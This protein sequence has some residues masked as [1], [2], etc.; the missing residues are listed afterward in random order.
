[1][2]NHDPNS[3]NWQVR[4]LKADAAEHF[5]ECDKR[6][7]IHQ[8]Y[9]HNLI[10]EVKYVVNTND[11]GL[12]VSVELRTRYIS[13]SPAPCEW[14][15]SMMVEALQL[16]LEVVKQCG[17][18]SILVR[19]AHF[20]N[21]V[22]EYGQPRFVDFDSFVPLEIGRAVTW[23]SYGEFVQC[24]FRPTV[25]IMRGYEQIVRSLMAADSVFNSRLT[26]L[27]HPI[28][29]ALI[30]RFRVDG[31]VTTLNSRVRFL[32]SNSVWN[33]ASQLS[34]SQISS[35]GITVGE[36][37]VVNIRY[38]KL[39]RLSV[40]FL[41]AAVKVSQFWHKGY[42][43]NVLTRHRVKPTYWSK[44][45]EEERATHSRFFE[46]Q[47]ILN[48]IESELLS[49]T[50]I[51]G[52]DGS[53]LHSLI[54]QKVLA[55]G[56]VLDNDHFALETG[57]KRTSKSG[58]PIVFAKVDLRNPLRPRTCDNQRFVSEIVVALAI[59]HHFL[60]V[61]KLDYGQ[62]F[63]IFK[64]FGRRWMIV[65]FMPLGL[66][67]QKTKVAVPRWYSIEAFETS[68]KEVAEVKLRQQFQ[69]GRITYLAMFHQTNSVDQ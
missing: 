1:M 29:G 25:L 33:V 39:L 50:D 9:A 22:F 66:D 12:T 43:Q 54:E 55:K 45:S 2:R 46:I 27:Q 11:D 56:I 19:D 10:P 20:D 23:P 26:F 65:D 63:R 64:T 17:E 36:T 3:E 53:L 16:Y 40:P 35:L 14:T 5:L 31:L 44:Y 37:R 49:A 67:G 52:N 6:G 57:R 51:G 61:E 28:F 24:M 41:S 47:N 68:L 38:W 21:I 8:L 59:T 58:L 69:P 7:M 15:Y 32:G 18:K 48:G 34:V 4:I 42:V 60:L 30:R 13:N 62:M